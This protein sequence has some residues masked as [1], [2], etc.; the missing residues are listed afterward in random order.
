MIE[1]STEKQTTSKFRYETLDGEQMFND[2]PSFEE[3]HKDPQYFQD[4]KDGLK[5][6]VVEM[7]AADY[8]KA[9]EERQP[10]HKKYG[11]DKDKMRNLEKAYEVG[12][13]VDIPI[14]AYGGRDK[15]NDLFQQEG[16]HRAATALLINKKFIPVA[17]RYRE[18]DSNI[19]YYI[20]MN[21]KHNRLDVLEREKPMPS[22]LHLAKVTMK[23]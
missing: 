12:I 9:V 15:H 17:I 6:I 8:M 5:A 2:N 18:D 23:I 14:L 7:L 3:I 19:P 1:C 16:Y 10:D 4:K 22:E 21:I 13:K 20:K 11:I